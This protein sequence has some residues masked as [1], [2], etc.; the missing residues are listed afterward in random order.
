MNIYLF[1]QTI[2]L[3]KLALK[4][5]EL[6]TNEIS[7]VLLVGPSTAIPKLRQLIENVLFLNKSIIVSH[8]ELSEVAVRGA[9]FKAVEKTMDTF[10]LKDKSYFKKNSFN[11][12]NNLVFLFFIVFGFG[13]LVFFLRFEQS[14]RSNRNSTRSSQ[15]IITRDI[16]AINSSHV[17]ERIRRLNTIKIN[18]NMI[19]G[20]FF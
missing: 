13:F 12:F 11:T 2:E 10:V 17:N 1:H 7:Q 9:S 3:A 19:R 14:I 15:D 4:E 6:D 16:E 5:S 8:V 20:N 18:Q